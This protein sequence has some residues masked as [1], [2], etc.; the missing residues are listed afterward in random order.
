MSADGWARV[1]VTPEFDFRATNTMHRLYSS[2]PELPAK[3]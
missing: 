3:A 1:T 2:Q